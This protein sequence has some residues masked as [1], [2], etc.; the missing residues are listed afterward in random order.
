M[1]FLPMLLAAGL[2]VGVGM[3]SAAPAQTPADLSLPKPGSYQLDHIM[4]A[5]HGAVLDS[6]G[7]ARRMAEF[8]TGNVT[9]ISLFYTACSVRRG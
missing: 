6:E 1:R 4:E 5:P 8:T 2:N 9:L 3:A 7:R